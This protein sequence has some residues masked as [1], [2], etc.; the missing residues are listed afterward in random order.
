MDRVVAVFFVLSRVNVLPR[1]DY[2]CDNYS[3]VLLSDSNLDFGSVPVP[4]YGIDVLGVV[5]HY[6]VL[7]CGFIA[8]KKVKMISFIDDLDS[9]FG[10][11]FF[12]R[13]DRCVHDHRDFDDCPD[14]VFFDQWCNSFFEFCVEFVDEINSLL[15]VSGGV[16]VTLAP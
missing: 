10:V 15:L 3:C 6:C 7:C 14:L 16:P 11:G 4:V 13:V 12:D 8:V 9:K 2:L 5:K 1:A